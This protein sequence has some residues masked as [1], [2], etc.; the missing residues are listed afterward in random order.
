MNYRTLGK[1]GLSV[2]E[3][4]YGAWG[5]GKGAWVG[6]SDEESL[7]ALHK[8]IDLGLNFIDTALAYGEGHSEKHWT[9]NA[10]RECVSSQP[11]VGE[12][13]SKANVE[14]NGET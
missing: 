14:L 4:G 3:I 1:T 2:S 11:Q 9:F 8:A 10:T 12:I 7:K 6:A 13:M 5:I